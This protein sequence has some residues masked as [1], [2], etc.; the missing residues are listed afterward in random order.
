MPWRTR[1]RDTPSDDGVSSRSMRLIG[2]RLNGFRNLE[3]ARLHLPGEG[4]ALLGRNAQGKT[5]LLEAIHYL[6]TFRSFRGAP[7]GEL[8]R[9]GENV[10][11]IEGEIG[12]EGRPSTGIAAA[13]Q[14]NPKKKR[15]T[16]DGTEVP[17]LADAVGSVASVLFTP[18]DSG[19]VRDGPSGR[20]RFLDIVLSLNEPGYLDS[21]L[22]FR[23]ALEQ[24]NAALRDSGGDAAFAWDEILVRAGARVVDWRARWISDFADLYRTCYDEVS[25]QEGA[26]IRYRP[27]VAGAADTEGPEGAREAYRLALAASRERE[28]RRRT[29]V[30]GPHRDDLE[31][32][33]GEGTGARDLRA[34]GSGGEQRTAALALRLLEVET[35]RRLRGREPILLLDDVF[36]ELDDERSKKVL[37]LLER[38]GAG[39]VILTAPKESEVRFRRDLLRKW[40][41]EGGRIET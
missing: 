39:Q 15:V 32:M 17:R 40:R 36:A 12:A 34:Y 26:S 33:I 8:V 25:G 29:T 5:N 13:F 3:D 28:R 22:E 10:F 11:R 21:L 31:L 24:R 4:I 2:L 37:A 9:F 16:A 38:T 30:V 20:R 19:L 18:E 7:D 14:R 1:R 6:E 23:R 35:A 27:S 41:I